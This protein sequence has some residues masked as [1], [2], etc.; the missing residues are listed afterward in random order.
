MAGTF[1]P[2]WR[3]VLRNGAPPRISERRAASASGSPLA[4]FQQVGE[5]QTEAI[6]V[7]DQKV[8]LSVKAVSRSGDHPG[9]RLLREC[10]DGVHV[11]H[12]DP[13]IHHRFFRRHAA[14]RIFGEKQLVAVF[15]LQLRKGL[16]PVR[17]DESELLIK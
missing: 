12:A 3:L 16:L 5:S 8:A 14:R 6:R 11:L 15:P 9:L 13:E 10:P 7:A 1:A 2:L 4:V 17:Y